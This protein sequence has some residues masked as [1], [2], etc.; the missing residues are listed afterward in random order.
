MDLVVTSPDG[1]DLGSTSDY[2]LDLS[3]GDSGNNFELWCPSLPI[4][5]GCTVAVEGTEWGGLVDTSEDSLDGGLSTTTW[6]GRTFHGVLVGKVLCPPA[7]QDYLTASGDANDCLRS[8]VARCGLS[9]TFE[10]PEGAAGI[11]VSHTFDRYCDAYS[12]IRKMLAS[13][14]ARLML[15]REDGRTLMWAEPAESHGDGIDSDLVDFTATRATRPVNHLVCAGSGE[16]A[17]RV[18]VHLYADAA[19]EVSRTQTL[20]GADEVAELYDYSSAD[21]D[22]LVSDGTRRLRGYQVQGSVDATVHEGLELYVGDTVCAANRETG[23][24]VTAAVNKK[25]VQAS[26]GVTAVSYEVGDAQT[27]TTGGTYASRETSSSGGGVT[28]VAGDGISIVGSRI[29]AEVTA[30]DLSE[31]SSQ[32]SKARTDAAQA[33]STWSA[34]SMSVGAVSTLPEGSKATAALSGEGLSKT[35]SLGIPAGATGATGPRGATGATGPTGPAGP[36]GEK[37]DR[38]P[39]GPQGEKGEPGDAGD[40]KTMFLAA[41]PVGSV[42]WAPPTATPAATYGG[43]WRAHQT[44]DGCAWERTG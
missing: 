30:D 11:A 7:G 35:L 31:V 13:S 8:L 32:A 27:G 26:G 24:T 10:V 2:A 1:T 22:T 36:Q 25:V 33:L 6:S 18:V 42:W 40:T 12:G 28:Y 19:G 16:L 44:T 20:F 23:R 15:R 43:T 5:Y 17:D 38:G 9:G 41:H 39:A 3:F 29:S 34:A 4:S 37:G 14:G 21:E